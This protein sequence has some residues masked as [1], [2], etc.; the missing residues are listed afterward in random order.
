MKMEDEKNGN[1]ALDKSNEDLDNNSNSDKSTNYINSKK[2]M[3]YNDPLNTGK[4]DYKWR[5]GFW[6]RLLA[7]IID[8]FIY[9]I[10]FLI[11]I[12]FLQ[13]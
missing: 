9:G 8:M 10:I 12:M 5:I 2:P 11:I 3:F 1:K 13:N 6:K 4:D 7:Y